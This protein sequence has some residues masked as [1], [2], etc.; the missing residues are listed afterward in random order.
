MRAQ[1]DAVHPASRCAS[2][3][4]RNPP[5][6]DSRE[7]A[8]RN[9][10]PGDITRTTSPGGGDSQADGAPGPGPRPRLPRGGTCG[11]GAP[12]PARPWMTGPDP[13]P[14]PVKTRPSASSGTPATARA[15]SVSGADGPW[16]KRTATGAEPRTRSHCAPPTPSNPPYPRPG[17][18]TVRGSAAGEA[19]GGQDVRG[20]AGPVLT[21]PATSAAGAEAST[22][23]PAVEAVV[24]APGA[25][26]GALAGEGDDPLLEQTAGPQTSAGTPNPGRTR[27]R[28][29]RHDN[30]GDDGRAGNRS[31][32][33][34]SRRDRTCITLP[35]AIEPRKTAGAISSSN[36]LR[37][38]RPSPA[39]PRSSR[40]G[41]P[42]EM[43]TWH[44]L[45]IIQR[46]IDTHRHLSTPRTTPGRRADHDHRLRHGGPRRD[47]RLPRGCHSRAPPP[48]TT[49]A[50]AGGAPGAVPGAAPA[51]YVL[52]LDEGATNAKAHA[53]APD[54]SIL[55][56]GSAA[57]AVSHP[58][59]GWVERDAEAVWAAQTAAI[60]DCLAGAVG[61]P[62]RHCDLQPARVRRRLRRR[63]RPGPGPFVAGFRERAGFQ[64]NARLGGAR[65]TGNLRVRGIRRRDDGVGRYL[66]RAACSRTVART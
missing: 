36:L 33:H 22:S 24:S 32:G 3:A 56:S 43:R 60:R 59:P 20:A 6:L 48:V 65:S 61:P 50:R 1:R 54:G 64:S 57:V 63:H 45:P 19:R 35:V 47:R 23:A 9:A 28:T 53:I 13:A 38:R 5:A 49:G 11:D 8:W 16:T 46:R 15:G 25:Y 30:P 55:A 31:T 7:P 29:P 12:L 4:R 18:L 51:S 58:R 42:P 52:P 40:P 27:H 17:R 66:A 39:A 26:D 10:S 44:A 14:P 21:R 34:S 2:S 41:L 37:G 62:G